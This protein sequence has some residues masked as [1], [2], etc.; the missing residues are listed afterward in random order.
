MDDPARVPPDQPIVC[1][2]RP[3]DEEQALVD[4][5]RSL[6]RDAYERRERTAAGV[7]WTFRNTDGIE[8]RVRTLAALEQGC[9]AFLTMEVEVTSD[10]VHWQVIGPDTAAEFL[11]EYYLLPDTIPVP[12]ADRATLS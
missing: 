3:G 4:R 7:R 11:D 8:E 12:P 5:Y 1:T 10:H 6:F 2:I 9:C